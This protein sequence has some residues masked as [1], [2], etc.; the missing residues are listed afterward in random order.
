MSSIDV[1]HAWLGPTIGP[2]LHYIMC[3]SMV[4][5]CLYYIMFGP[6]VGP[7]KQEVLKHT[8][9][10]TLLAKSQPEQ[11][12]Y[13]KAIGFSCKHQLASHNVPHTHSLAMTRSFEPTSTLARIHDELSLV[14][15]ANSD[16]SLRET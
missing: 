7:C 12:P 16:E 10:L 13:A 4:G 14:G 9:F 6:M 1:T 8:R 2:C 15:V 5:P 3:G 11:I